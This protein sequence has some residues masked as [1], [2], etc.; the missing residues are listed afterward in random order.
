MVI[1]SLLRCQE[2][3]FLRSCDLLLGVKID[4]FLRQQE[5]G[6]AK[7][8]IK[9]FGQFV[10]NHSATRFLFGT[11]L[12]LVRRKIN[13]WQND[14][15]AHSLHKQLFADKSRKQNYQAKIGLDYRPNRKI[16][17]KRSKRRNILNREQQKKRT[18]RHERSQR[19]LTQLPLFFLCSLFTCVD[20]VCRSIQDPISKRST[21]E[22]DVAP[23]FFLFSYSLFSFSFSFLSFSFLSF[24]F[25]LSSLCL[26][27]DVV[28]RSI[29]QDPILSLD[30]AQKDRLGV[31]GP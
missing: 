15:F 2:R 18:E 14:F 20:V 22:W 6:N 12:R 8:P 11:R 9:P 4:Q 28:C 7:K 16:R 27:V 24:S 1:F 10:R 21:G 30:W 31:K 17:F 3:Q 23:L 26:P 19:F 29:I 13:S 5:K 25:V